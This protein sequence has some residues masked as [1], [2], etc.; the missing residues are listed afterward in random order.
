MLVYRGRDF[1]LGRAS[2]AHIEHGGGVASQS[3][4]IVDR[5][6]Q[7]LFERQRYWHCDEAGCFLSVQ[8]RMFCSEK[9]GERGRIALASVE[10]MGL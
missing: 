8:E 10:P 4:H 1:R 3:G 7:C 5:L 9:M 2:R 6:L